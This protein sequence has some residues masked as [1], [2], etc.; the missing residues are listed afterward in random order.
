M[1]QLTVS[2]QVILKQDSN[3]YHCYTSKENRILGLTIL[4]KLQQDTIIKLYDKRILVKDSI[5]TYQYQALNKQDTV[6][7]LQSKEIKET[8]RTLQ[9]MKYYKYTTWT[10]GLTT[11]LFIL[12]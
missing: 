12:L 3:I 7:A 2:S 5:I 1:I 10:L 8:K 4:E 11:L 9:K 6:I